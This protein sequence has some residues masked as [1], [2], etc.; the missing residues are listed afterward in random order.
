MSG[1]IRICVREMQ[2][3]AR[4]E[5]LHP[6]SPLLP[7]QN[8][9]I[10]AAAVAQMRTLTIAY[11]EVFRLCMRFS[12]VHLAESPPGSL[13][14]P[15]IDA[16]LSAL[17]THGPS[18]SIDLISQVSLLKSMIQ[19][20]VP[21]PRESLLAAEPHWVAVGFEACTPSELQ[22]LAELPE[23]LLQCQYVP[24]PALVNTLC[25]AILHCGMPIQAKVRW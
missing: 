6:S 7:F 19:L 21:P 9:A 1:L 8:M 23:V 5:Q 2:Q 24:G 22:A 16:Q 15:A 20:G 11:R 13:K 12:A 25:H 10:M 17:P 14:L 4:E 3:Q 18:D